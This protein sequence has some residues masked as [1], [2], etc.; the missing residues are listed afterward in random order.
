MSRDGHMRQNSAVVSRDHQR[1]PRRAVGFV[2]QYLYLT[3]AG[4]CVNADDL[5]VTA[6]FAHRTL[7]IIWKLRENP[8]FVA[9]WA[10]ACSAAVAFLGSFWFVERVYTN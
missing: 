4:G 7:P 8:M 3:S 9:R 10:P 2:T 5:L 6:Q 1:R